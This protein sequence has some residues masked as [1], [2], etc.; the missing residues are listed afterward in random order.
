METSSLAFKQMENI[1]GF[2]RGCRA[3]GV[4]EFEVFETADLY[5]QKNID[6]VVSQ[7]LGI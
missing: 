4:Q 1:S 5:D 3:V 7:V 6:L 2:L